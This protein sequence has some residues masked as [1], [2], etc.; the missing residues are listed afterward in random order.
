MEYLQPL[1]RQR[2]VKPT[3]SPQFLQLPVDVI[4]LITDELKTSAPESTIALSATCKTLYQI[5]IKYYNE[6]DDTQCNAFLAL[7][8]REVAHERYHCATCQQLHRFKKIWDPLGLLRPQRYERS[9]LEEHSGKSC[10][11]AATFNPSGRPSL[12]EL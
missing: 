4:L 8:E 9:V 5:L 10:L 7:A 2:A 6:R 3:T 12:Y 11:R 1:L